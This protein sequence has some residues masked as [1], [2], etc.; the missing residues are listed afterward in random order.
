[1]RKRKISTEKGK[2]CHVN[3]I[4]MMSLHSWDVPPYFQSIFVTPPQKRAD[5]LFYEE[6]SLTTEKCLRTKGWARFKKM[7]RGCK[8]VRLFEDP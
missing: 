5:G 3:D 8:I 1:M 4:I 2:A 7:V 6:P